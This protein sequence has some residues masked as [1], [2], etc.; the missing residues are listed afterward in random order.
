M[1]VFGISDLAVSAVMMFAGSTVLSTLGFGIGVSTTPVLLMALDAQTVVVTVN[2]LSVAVFALT[3]TQT[4]RYLPVR[5]MMPV[6]IAGLLGVPLGV[7]ILS[8][9]SE[10]ALRISIT[11]LIILLTIAFVFRTRVGIRVPRPLGP[12]VG[13]VVGLLLISLGIGGPL[14]VLFLLS[15]EWTRHVVRASL[16]FYFLVV[17]LSGVIGYGVAGLFTEERISLILIVTVPTL[18]GFAL[19]SFLVGRMSERVFQHAVVAVIIVTSV[20]VL[21]REIV[22]A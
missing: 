17:E 1:A 16:A 7:W 2:T 22:G 10:S 5:E 12:V 11:A 20:M 18:L 13:F 6:T 3:L 4:R 14:V 15:R 8:S 19:G 9:A 21:G